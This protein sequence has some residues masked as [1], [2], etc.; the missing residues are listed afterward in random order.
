[1]QMSNGKS[2]KS[3]SGLSMGKKKGSVETALLPKNHIE[4]LSKK[5]SNIR[6]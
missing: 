5:L 6:A 1:L 4:Q 3:G 2:G